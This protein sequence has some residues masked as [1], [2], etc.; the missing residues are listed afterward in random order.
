MEVIK[1]IADAQVAVDARNGVRDRVAEGISGSVWRRLWQAAA[2]SVF[3]DESRPV[4]SQGDRFFNRDAWTAR[5]FVGAMVDDLQRAKRERRDFG[6]LTLEHVARWCAIA[7]ATIDKFRWG[8]E[9]KAIVIAATADKMNR[10][11]RDAGIG[12]CIHEKAHTKYSCRRRLNPTEMFALLEPVWDLVPSWA[13]YGQAILDWGN[14]IEDCRIERLTCRQYRG[15]RTP[16]EE[17]QDFILSQ[18]RAGL[19][20]AEHRGLPTK[21]AL[22]VISGAFRDVGLGYDTPSQRAALNGYESD[23]PEGWAFV[24]EGPL[25]PLLDATIALGEKKRP[26]RGDD[27][28]HL[29]L[30]M[31]VVAAIS[32]ASDSPVE[33]GKGCDACGAPVS[34]LRSRKVPGDRSKIA[35]V[36]LVCGHTHEIDREEPPQ[37]EAEAE[38]GAAPETDEVQVEDPYAEQDDS[39]GGEESDREVIRAERDD[40]EAGD[41]DGDGEADEDGSED[42]DSEEG[43]DTDSEDGDS[44]SED[45]DSDGED[46]DT[47]DGDSD[48][49]DSTDEGDDGDGE[50]DD[51]SAEGGPDDGG[52]ADGADSA[53]EGG[54]DAG[55]GDSD[56]D[57]GHLTEEM[58]ADL[59]SDMEEGDGNGLLDSLTALS[60]VAEKKDADTQ[61]GEAAWQ[62]RGMRVVIPERAPEGRVKMVEKAARRVA[63]A[64]KVQLRRLFLEARR[65]ETFHGVRKGQGLSTRR[66]VPS[67]LEMRHGMRPTRPD[68]T[69]TKRPDVT[70][71]A[72]IMTD[73]SGSMRG[74]LQKNAAIA[75]MA[76][77]EAL[78]SLKVPTFIGGFEGGTVDV[79]K[80]WHQSHLEAKGRV[81]QVRAAGGTPTADGIQMGLRALSERDERV[82]VLFV[83]TDGHPNSRDLPVIAHQLR[84]AKENGVAIV[85]VGIGSGTYAVKTVFPDHHVCV[86][87]VKDLPDALMNTLRALV[88][89]SKARRFKVA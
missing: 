61:K 13:L 81:A 66:L 88:F 42:A 67:A 6:P 59:M 16:L 86:N 89:P 11:M 19:V 60:D 22:R 18:E 35:I 62:D 79:F 74:A 32:T 78:D 58:L 14:L 9:A 76:L 4:F 65:A 68:Y 82:R 27:L 71:A 36:C 2:D 21:S 39:E 12:G 47:D 38:G 70:L 55:G 44:D 73:E 77:S 48:E 37:T 31:R 72:A 57:A 45:G 28:A 29:V 87:K 7:N 8:S 80:D 30:A 51:D 54:D 34:K 40:P 17:L 83:I 53:D 33:S 84:L 56:E 63:G 24:M 1:E 52:D 64:A 3:P 26:S 46:G 49:G 41:E 43:E 25:R 10:S 85:G 69:T 75:Q 20:A 23:S 50:A 15:A 5:A